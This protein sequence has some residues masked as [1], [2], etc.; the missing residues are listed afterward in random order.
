MKLHCDITDIKRV[1]S[2]TISP[3]LYHNQMQ[4]IH[5]VGESIE[6]QLLF[7]CSFRTSTKL[8]SNRWRYSQT[9][10]IPPS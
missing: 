9:S 8:V 10:K 1:N 2:N 4:Q 7:L 5:N 6:A 3:R